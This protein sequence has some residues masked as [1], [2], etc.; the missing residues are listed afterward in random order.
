MP[1]PPSLKPAA[2]P[3]IDEQTPL[4]GALAAVLGPLARLA[5]AR[6]VPFAAV[7][8]QLKVA[9]INAARDAQAGSGQ[10]A[11][12][13]VSRISTTTGINRREVTRITQ[14]PVEAAGPKA[15]S[16]ASEVFTRWRSDRKWLQGGQYGGEPKVLPRLGP[17][18]SFEVLARSV[19]QDVHPRSLLDELC[20]IGLATHDE[21]ADT[22]SLSQ[23]AFVPRGDWQRMLAFL[24]DNVGDHLQGA[25][26][27][28]L[29]D[30]GQHF[31]Q[32]IFAD[33]LSQESLQ[34]LRDMVRGYWQQMLKEVVPQLEKRIEE[35]RQAGRPQDRRVR[36]GLFT[37]QAPMA[38]PE[39][40]ATPT[41]TRTP[42]PEPC[43]KPRASRAKRAAKP[44]TPSVSKT[45]SKKA[46]TKKSQRS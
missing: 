6:G 31:E 5:V 4:L 18:A 11:H 16:L 7:E 35:D 21:A 12:R 45:A 26:D 39:V 37:Y 46:A 38:V 40:D 19:T 33:E 15:V 41:P 17:K 10:P 29:S 24:G 13:L 22:V 8:E 1:S 32:A 3:Q 14:A 34:S 28:V 25:V 43:S 36:L 42:T 44:A 30:G 9:F 23:E 20:R 2:S 27:N